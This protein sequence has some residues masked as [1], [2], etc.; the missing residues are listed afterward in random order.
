MFIAYVSDTAIKTFA[1]VESDA[2]DWLKVSKGQPVFMLSEDNWAIA[3]EWLNQ[4]EAYGGAPVAQTVDAEGREPGAD[5]YVDTWT[6]GEAP[7]W[8][9]VGNGAHM[10][11]GGIL[12]LTHPDGTLGETLMAENVIKDL[13]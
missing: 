9:L 6:S 1:N 11:K 4:G 12:Q 2:I 10:V 8:R 7:Q 3:N 13:D 5:G